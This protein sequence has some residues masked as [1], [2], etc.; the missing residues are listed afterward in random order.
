M[1]H[2]KLFEQYGGKPTETKWYHGTPD[3][4]EVDELGG[5]KSNMTS[6]EYVKD[7]EQYKEIQASLPNLRETDE[8]EY[9][10]VL[11]TVSKLRERYEYK[12]PLFIS[13]SYS[14]AKTYADPQRSFDYQ[15]A[16][17]KVYQVETEC[18]KLVK[19]SA[20]GDRFRF[21]NVDK[22]K[23]G[24]INAGISE[25]E[26]TKVIEQFNFSVR[27]KSGIKTDAIASIGNWFGFDCIDVIGVLDSYH[28]GT[29]KSTVRMVLDPTKVKIIK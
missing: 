11:G 12:S 29:I 13:D 4:R 8:D 2:I 17:E 27:D 26:I 21:I 25:E 28:G 6:T 20:Y 10:R 18:N 1:K 14:V 3:G 7:I 22:V 5:F 24:F 16:E 15:N 9:F 23:R 19:I